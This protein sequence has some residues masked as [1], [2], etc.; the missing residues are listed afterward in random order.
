MNGYL[1]AQLDVLCHCYLDF[2]DDHLFLY[3][4]DRKISHINVLV[5]G[6]HE[7][8]GGKLGVVISTDIFQS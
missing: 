6:R 2:C 5:N 1:I 7:F 3:P 4:D 8:T